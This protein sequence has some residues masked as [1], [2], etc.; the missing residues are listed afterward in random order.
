M[1]NRT[2]PEV[3]LD[4]LGIP[5]SMMP[6]RLVGSGEIVGGLL[7]EVAEE[8]GLEPGTPCVAG[9]VDAAIATYAAGVCESGDHVA[10]I[11][12]S[13]CWGFINN[14]TDAKHGLISMPHVV[15]SEESIYVFGGAISAGAS[16]SWFIDEFC[17]AEKIEAEKT[18]KNVHA[19]LEEK[20]TQIRPGSD[21]LIFCLI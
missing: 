6:K 12:T 18:S 1:D 5:S 17:Q 11:G 21:G 20:A 15:H 19:I 14:S 10:M 9:G 4:M 7:T 16:I 2:W 13:M 3:R 8:L